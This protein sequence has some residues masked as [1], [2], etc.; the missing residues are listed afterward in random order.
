[1]T[2]YRDEPKPAETSTPKQLRCPCHV[3]KSLTIWT[4]A[5]VEALRSDLDKQEAR[6][7]LIHAWQQFDSSGHT[8]AND[9]QAAAV[10]LDG[11]AFEMQR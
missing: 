7:V 8:T 10:C 9:I 4:I 6:A 11:E 5:D 1:M 3:K 2:C